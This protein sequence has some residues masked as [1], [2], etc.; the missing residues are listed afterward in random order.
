[1]KKNKSKYIGFGWLKFFCFWRPWISFGTTVLLILNLIGYDEY[2]TIYFGSIFG[3]ISL[4]LLLIGITTMLIVFFMAKK[5]SSDTI[6][7]IDWALKIEIIEF[8]YAG[9]LQYAVNL[10]YFFIL[11]VIL[12]IIYYFLWY[13]LNMKY[14]EKREFWFN[15][16]CEPDDINNNYIEEPEEEHNINSYKKQN[17]KVINKKTIYCK[18]CGGK[19]NQEKKC[20]KCGKQYFKMKINMLLY[21]IIGILVFSNLTFILLYEDAKKESNNIIENKNKDLENLLK[22]R[23]LNY[24]EEKIDFY[25]DNIVFVVE[26]YENFA[27]QYDCLDK[28]IEEEEYSFWAYNRELDLDKGYKIINCK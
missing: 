8:A 7:A 22:G 28:Y 9:A 10:T 20:T 13:K 4:G 23:T 12:C 2:R 1:M 18:K 6:E 26:G 19:L 15:S 27:Y 14:F 11:F 5:R 25:D 24:L 21:F 16:N 3:Y 17:K